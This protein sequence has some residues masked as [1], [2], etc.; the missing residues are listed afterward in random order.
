MV[1]L[2]YPSQRSSYTANF[3]IF[4]GIVSRSRFSSSYFPM[5]RFCAQVAVDRP[6]CVSDLLLLAL[7]SLRFRFGTWRKSDFRKNRGILIALWE[8]HS[9][10]IRVGIFCVKRDDA[11]V[12]PIPSNPLAHQ[13][14]CLRFKHY[15]RFWW[16]GPSDATNRDALHL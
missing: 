3:W 11:M 8:F 6:S 13:H 14:R 4:S 9:A 2:T 10:V 15:A 16:H 12:E 5:E 1:T 7:R